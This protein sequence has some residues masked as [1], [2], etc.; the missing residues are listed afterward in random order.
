[1]ARPLYVATSPISRWSSPTYTGSVGAGSGWPGRWT[2][3]SSVTTR[4]SS[5]TSSTRLRRT[6]MVKLTAR[7]S[8]SRPNSYRETPITRLIWPLPSPVC[9]AVHEQHRCSQ[10]RQAGWMG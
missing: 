8:G 4:S 9:G 2:C 10:L 3:G 6:R 7:W 5:G 1:M